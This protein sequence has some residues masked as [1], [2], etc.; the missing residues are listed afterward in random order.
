M[1]AADLQVTRFRGLNNVADP[2]RLGLEWL[3]TANN[4]NILD[5]GALERRDGYGLDTAGTMTGAYST[6]DYQRLYLVDA[7][8]LKTGDGATLDTISSSERMHWAEINGDV[9]FNNGT[10]TGIIK[11]D[12]TVLPWSWPV[13]GTPTLAAVSGSLAPGKYDVIC[14]YLM[15]DGRETGAGQATSI[16]IEEGQALQISNIPQA[17]GM[18]ARVYIAPAN[19]T[20]FQLAYE[21]YQTARLWDYSPNSLGIDLATDD[22]D[23]IPEGATLIQV[24]RGRVYAAQYFPAS[25][26]TAVWSSQPL[27]FHLFDLASDFLAIPGEVLM[28]APTDEALLIGTGEEIHA[29]TGDSIKMLANYGVVPGW[30]WA[31]DDEDQKVYIW[32]QRGMCRAMPFTNLTSGHVS[33][34]PGVQAGAAVIAQDGQR[35][36]V[37]ALHQGGQAFNQR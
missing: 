19:S 26:M 29:Y 22:F 32:T 31:I 36:F 23:P 10:D 1:K 17:A 2:M 11:A 33:V 21:G 18:T 15:D 9:F 24:W 6:V 20:V 30:C 12:N 35:R 37:V 27:G 14:T 5:T 13:P 28:L 4:I 25:N 16:D 8:S 7:G 3:T 34:A